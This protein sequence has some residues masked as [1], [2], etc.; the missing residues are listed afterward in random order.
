MHHCRFAEGTLK[1][2]ESGKADNPLLS[3]FSYFRFRLFILQRFKQLFLLAAQYAI[4]PDLYKPVWQYMH[5]K[6]TEKLNS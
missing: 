4:I 2:V 3:T 6:P 5:A 1:P